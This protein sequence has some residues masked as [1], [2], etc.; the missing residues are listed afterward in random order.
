VKVGD[1]VKSNEPHTDICAPAPA[2]TPV[3]IVYRR[4]KQNARLWWVE[5][6]HPTE[7]SGDRVCQRDAWLEI[8]SENK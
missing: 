6:V 7:V 1:L 2:S 8:L 5:W 4:H 3:G